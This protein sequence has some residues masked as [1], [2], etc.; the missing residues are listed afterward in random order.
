M[1]EKYLPESRQPYAG[2]HDTVSP[3][4]VTHSA[5]QVSAD[6]GVGIVT[7]GQ[8]ARSD[9]VSLDRNIAELVTMQSFQWIVCAAFRLGLVSGKCL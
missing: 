2:Y 1:P 8:A 3:E 9:Q 7:K 6:R 4:P 5:H